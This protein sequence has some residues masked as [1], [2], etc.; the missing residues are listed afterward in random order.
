MK[1]RNGN[2]VF[3]G[4]FM[5]HKTYIKNIRFKRIAPHKLRTRSVICCFFQRPK[6]W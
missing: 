5:F 6:W 3:V 4:L 2:I 1:K